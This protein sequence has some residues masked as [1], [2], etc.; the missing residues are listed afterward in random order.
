MAIYLASQDN[1]ENGL[2]PTLRL[3]K[4]P[5]AALSALVFTPNPKQPVRIHMAQNGNASG[6]N[7]RNNVN[8]VSAK[9]GTNGIES[10]DSDGQTDCLEED[11]GTAEPEAAGFSITERHEG[12]DYRSFAANLFA[13]VAF[14][15]L[16]WL[17]PSGVEEM[18]RMAHSFRSDGQPAGQIPESQTPK[19][20]PQS[21]SSSP[22]SKA[23]NG[24]K[25]VPEQGEDAVA[26]ESPR[27]SSNPRNHQGRIG[28]SET[29]MIN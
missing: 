22:M 25:A 21:R 7:Q 6:A 11:D 8:N 2:C 4:T 13:T 5:P 28:R 16:E 27:A 3:P 17:T 14:K 26:E 9:K 20:R 12:K 19:A 18:S 10:G 29:R 23:L 24:T 1:A 15:M